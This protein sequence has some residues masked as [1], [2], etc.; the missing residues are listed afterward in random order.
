VFRLLK[1]RGQSL[2]PDFQE[3]DY[4]LLLRDSFP[5]LRIKTGDVIVFDQ[6]PLGRL[7]KQVSQVLD[8]GQSFE[9]RGS[10][11]SSTD[12][13]DFGPVPR[14]CV[15]G[16]VIWHIKQQRDRQGPSIL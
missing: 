1:V 7:I 6:P 13:R 14:T 3:E 4:V 10:Q 8:S 12:S 9:V 5:G 11:I 16:K 15:L 2:Y